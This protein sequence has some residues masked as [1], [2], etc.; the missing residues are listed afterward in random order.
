M[1]RWCKTGLRGIALVVVIH[2]ML[3]V[4]AQA[5]PQAAPTAA[6]AAPRPPAAP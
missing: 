6:V 2:N 1:N 4:P 5:A 3:V